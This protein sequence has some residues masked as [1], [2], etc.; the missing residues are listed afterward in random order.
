MFFGKSKKP[1]FYVFLSCC[2]RFLEQ[3]LQGG[4][5]KIP[6]SLPETRLKQKVTNTIATDT[7]RHQEEENANV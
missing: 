4:A 5:C 3:W 1:N 2:T 6:H 7:S